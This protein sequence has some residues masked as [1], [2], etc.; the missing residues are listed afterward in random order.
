MNAVRISRLSKRFGAVRALDEVSLDIEQGEM[1]FLLGPSGCGKTT[2]L[3]ALAGFCEPDGGEIFFDGENV[4]RLPAYLRRTGMVFQNYALWPHLNVRQNVAFGLEQQKLPRAEIEARVKEALERV[5]MSP[6]AE[7]SPNTLSGGQQ[8]RVAL[9]RAMAVRPRCLLLDEPLSNLDARLR[10]QLRGD[11]RRLCK[12]AGLTSVYVTHDQKE[13][14]A[15]A[16]RIAVMQ[17]GKICQV[18]APQEV[19][20]RPAS[21]FVAGFL[22]ESDFFEG[23]VRAV[24]AG[25]GLIACALGEFRAALGPDTASQA[26]K[27]GDHALLCV[28]PEAWHLDC[29]PADENCLEGKVTERV[30]LG[31]LA[32]CVF[33]PDDGKPPVR[34]FTLNPRGNVSGESQYAWIDPEDAVILPR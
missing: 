5:Q 21:A 28:R 27:A 7:S 20:R 14:M 23:E 3:R 12:E 9:A 25:E 18:G 19:Y 11:I 34:L 6:W 17:D 13:A 15:M 31:E 10:A 26:L 2:L 33:Q 1:F 4:T 8:Q 22:G 30:F 29:M 32:Q 24:G 16:D